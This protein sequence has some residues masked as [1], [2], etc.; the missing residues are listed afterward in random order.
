M[1][2][3]Y[4]IGKPGIGKSTLVRNILKLVK[5]MSNERYGLLDYI[6]CEGINVLGIYNPGDIFCGLDKT[7]MAVQP[8]AESFL[9]YSQSHEPEQAI[10][11]EGDRLAS[12]GFL[13]SCRQ[14]GELRLISLH[15]NDRLLEERRG[16]RNENVGKA[17]DSAWLKGRESKVTNLEK[18]FEAESWRVD[19]PQQS[20]ELAQH[21]TDWLLGRIESPAPKSKRLF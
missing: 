5:P 17:Q 18:S 8:D 11:G 12:A 1:R 13:R 21:L 3:A 10:L 4:I 2:I 7:S 16:A 14:V 20:E 15:T 9:S 19:I 6:R